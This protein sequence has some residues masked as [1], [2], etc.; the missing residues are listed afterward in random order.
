MMRLLLLCLLM[1]ALGGCSRFETQYG[2]FS[3]GSSESSINGLGMLRRSF[4]NVKW[5]TKKLSRLSER[6]EA[7]DVIVWAPA[8]ATTLYDDAREWFEDWLAGGNHTLVYII[9]DDGCDLAYFDQAR[10]F[11]PPEQQ[12]E[13]RR[14]IAQLQSAQLMSHLQLSPMIES[15]WFVLKP[16]PR[17]E[18]ISNQPKDHWQITKVASMPSANTRIPFS[19][20][21]YR[22]EALTPPGNQASTSGTSTSPP[23]TCQ[24]PSSNIK[25]PLAQ[26]PI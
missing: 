12:L 18:L 5:D 17:N 25:F 9:P 20:I 24:A 13:Y 14:R 8:D 15:G 26:P 4:E 6:A 23:R 11:A 16:L 3:G 10:Q 1:I 21:Q 22:L 19:G 2:E 7:F